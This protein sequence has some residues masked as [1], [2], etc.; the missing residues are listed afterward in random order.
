MPADT[1]PQY[2][3]YQYQSADA[4]RLPPVIPRVVDE[5]IHIGFTVAVTATAGEDNE[6][7][8]MI[9]LAHVVVLHVP[10]ALT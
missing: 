4:P 8:V 1:P 10:S 2:P 7:T 3:L 9:M 6:L 5:P